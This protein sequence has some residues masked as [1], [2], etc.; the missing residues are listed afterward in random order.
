MKSWLSMLW[1]R[2]KPIQDDSKL[3]QQIRDVQ[4]VEDKLEKDEHRINGLENRVKRIMRENNL[5]PAIV[6]ALKVR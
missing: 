1:R 3:Q 5:A 4:Q 2:V 6:R